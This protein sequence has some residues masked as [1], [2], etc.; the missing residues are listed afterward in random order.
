MKH[1]IKPF[2]DQTFNIPFDPSDPDGIGKA[3][4]IRIPDTFS[5]KAKKMA[6][7]LKDSSALYLYKNRF[8]YT[9]ESLNLTG[10]PDG[11][12]RLNGGPRWTGDSLEAL[13]TWLEEGADENDREG[14]IPGWNSSQPKQP[15]KTVA[16]WSVYEKKDGQI[17]DSY[18]LRTRTEAVWRMR[19]F[20]RE[21]LF[22][23]PL[24]TY[25]G[26]AD[27]V[28]TDVTEQ[29]KFVAQCMAIKGD[30]DPKG[31]KLPDVYHL[32]PLPLIDVCKEAKEAGYH[33][34]YDPNVLVHRQLDEFIEELD[35]YLGGM[36]NLYVRFGDVIVRMDGAWQKTTEV[37]RLM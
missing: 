35:P 6:E 23:L 17:L 10:T 8:V 31:E 30:L 34:L 19:C 28:A 26:K 27:L 29:D 5:P 33:A 1:L 36:D 16:L 15:K 14:N 24:E 22:E 9:D 25:F 37:Y 13:E 18:F 4:E 2:E 20:I 3:I 7:Y 11:S 12:G 21:N 32:H